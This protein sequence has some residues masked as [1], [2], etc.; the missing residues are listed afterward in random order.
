[1]TSYV[2]IPLLLTCLK[3]GFE[4]VGPCATCR[5]QV[6][7]KSATKKCETYRKPAKSVFVE[8]RR[9]TFLVGNMFPISLG[10]SS[11]PKTE[12]LSATVSSTRQKWWN[13]GFNVAR[14]FFRSWSKFVVIPVHVFQGRGDGPEAGTSGASEAAR[15]SCR[16][17]S[18]G[19]LPPPREIF[20]QF[21]NFKCHIVR[22]SASYAAS[23][24]IMK[25]FI[26]AQFT[27]VQS[28]V[29]RSHVVRLSVRPSVSD[30]GW[31]WSHR[32]KIL[33][34]NCTDN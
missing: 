30:V 11:I 22:F 2:Q 9:T 15:A 31:L 29:L 5:P 3:P 25:I 27:L 28:A 4:Q 33:E 6:S 23:A 7:D 24:D 17:G 20:K 26:T 18:S 34:T 13:L 8:V 19:V 10:L 21:R 16:L 32:S 12:N 1:M 14:R